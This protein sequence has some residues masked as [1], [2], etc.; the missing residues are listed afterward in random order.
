MP[1][2]SGG[3][4]APLGE[5]LQAAGR[6][7]ARNV[8]ERVCECVVGLCLFPNGLAADVEVPGMPDPG[9]RRRAEDA[10]RS[11]GSRRRGDLARVEMG[12]R[13]RLVAP[14]AGGQCVDDLQH[15]AQLR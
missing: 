15:A 7:G 9:E 10:G 11:D 3:L 8:R 4:I 13:Q 14:D 1:A 5:D 2:M 6:S 12:E